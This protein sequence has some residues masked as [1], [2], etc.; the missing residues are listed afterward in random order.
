MSDASKLI[1]DP[2]FKSSTECPVK[3]LYVCGKPSLP[4]SLTYHREIEIQYIKRGQG[5]YFIHDHNYS[6]HKN[7]LLVIRPD[8]LHRI[9]IELTPYVE[10]YS[11]CF[12]ADFL[13][14]ESYLVD[15]PDDFPRLFALSERE[16][17]V[18]EVIARNIIAEKESK[19]S[20]WVEMV[21]SEL[22]RLI[23]LI[24]RVGITACL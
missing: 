8:E 11:I 10:K 20:Y 2:I 4:S 19:Q 3:I 21:Y 1:G 5:A 9:D 6:F 23:L 13:D 12:A 16:A 24:R 22:L 7:S 17:A 18:T 15:L 14:E